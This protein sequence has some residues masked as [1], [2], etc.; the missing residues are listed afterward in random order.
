MAGVVVPVVV[1][2]ELAAPVV[3]V[4]AG[5]VPP[6]AGVLGLFDLAFTLAI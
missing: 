3:D 2:V 6:A 4:A 5:V 1:E